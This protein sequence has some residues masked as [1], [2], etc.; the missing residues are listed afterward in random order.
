MKPDLKYFRT[1]EWLHND[2]K[3]H[4][5]LDHHETE[6]VEFLTF[7]RPG[8][9]CHRIHYMRRHGCLH[10]TG[11]LGSA[12]YNWYSPNSLEWIAGLNLGYFA[13]KCEASEK[14]SRFTEWDEDEARGNL[15]HHL[16][17]FDEPCEGFKSGCGSCEDF[18]EDERNS[19]CCSSFKEQ[20]KADSA[21]QEITSGSEHLYSEESWAQY[22]NDNDAGDLL[23]DQ[24]YWEWAYGIGTVIAHRCECHLAG[25]KFA[26]AIINK[27]ID[28][29]LRYM[30]Q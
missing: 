12:I 18:E 6:G 11:D 4:A 20:S 26:F 2:F 23:R 17:Q 5:I 10:V 22:L 16:F 15:H 28:D 24:D 1:K 3:D 13:G 29:S 21:W 27:E 9:S 8:T 7:G 14:G 19:K 25:L 30:N